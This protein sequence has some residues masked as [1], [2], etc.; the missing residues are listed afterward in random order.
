M[1]IFSI[2]SSVV[3]P[4]IRVLDLGGMLS[5]V[6]KL[7]EVGG[8]VLNAASKALT[9]F[10]KELGLIE[11]EEAAELGTKVIQAE[12]E[13]I[14]PENYEKFADYVKDIEKFEIDEEKA[15][16]ISEED[17]LIAG[18]AVAIKAI[19]DKFPEQEVENLIEGAVLKPAYFEND[20]RFKELAKIVGDDS[21]KLTAIGKILSGAEM[22]DDEYYDTLDMITA[23]EA[24]AFP[25]L[26]GEEVRKRVDD[27]L[28]S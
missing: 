7:L 27:L 25:E 2:F 21:D 13:G 15:K 10:A 5:A 24:A 22:D 11:T 12:E 23:A 4:V 9:T 26:D 6:A 14:K 20:D 1:G 16:D 28:R 19:E 8:K 17:K 3:G 18:T